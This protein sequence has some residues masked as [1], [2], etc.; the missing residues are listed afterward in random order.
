MPPFPQDLAARFRQ[1]AGRF[2]AGLPAA[3]WVAL[4]VAVALNAPTLW[5]RAQALPEGMSAAM[6]AGVVASEV[7]LLLSLT[8][9]L[10][11]VATLAGRWVWRG[12]A[13][14]LIVI[15][16]VC[17]FYMTRFNVVI[18]YGVI[19]AVFTTDHDMSGEVVGLW[20]FVWVALLGLLPLWWL[21]RGQAAPAL[22]RQWRQPRALLRRVLTVV[23]LAGVFSVAQS[24]LRHSGKQAVADAV[25]AAPNPVGVAAHSYVPSN[26]LAG[27]GMVASNKLAARS[28]EKRLVDPAKKFIY[29]PQT[30]LSD[31]VLVFVLGET[32]RHDRFGLLGHSRPT[33]PRL[34]A[35]PNVVG[36]A[37]TSCDTVTK[38]SLACMFVRPEGIQPDANLGPDLILEDNVFS[39]LH[40]LGFGIELFAMQSEV[41]FYNR[42]KAR[43]YKF[44]EVIAAQPE[45]A[46]KPVD[47]MLLL[48]ELQAS[49]AAATAAGQP[50]KPFAVVLHTKGSHYLYTQRYPRSFARWQPECM[51]TD[52]GCS[53]EQFLN[54]FDNSILYTDHVLAE[55]IALLKSHK[56]LLVYASDHGESISDNAHFHG[57]PRRIAPPEQRAVPL[58]FWA[59]DRF[60]A[61]PVLKAGYQRLAQRQQV[62]VPGVGHRNLFASLLG[63]LGVASPNGGITAG[64]NLCQ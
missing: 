33:T 41:G 61:D 56:A 42:V 43:A 59:S 54:S 20:L 24:A 31:V 51:S 14:L 58:I 11:A 4:Y 5:R 21:W 36:F 50:R 37:A 8:G 55:T 49:L 64:D 40:K 29:T 7:L 1:S 3:G 2:F 62:G 44:R 18:G 15:S 30:D 32:A 28:Q 34:A 23:L 35:T 19:N 48:P 53:G 25:E 45:N 22:W 26:W 46:G 60:L 52:H 16:A 63:C 12:V 6:Q 47:D 17:A 13:S 57:T 27:V 9:L 10:C 39:V 38:L